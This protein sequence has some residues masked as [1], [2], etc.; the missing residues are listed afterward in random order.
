M[1]QVQPVGEVSP[2]SQPTSTVAHSN[3]HARRSAPEQ[4]DELMQVTSMRGWIALAGFALLLTAA[5]AWGLFGTVT[6]DVSGQ[7]VLVRGG[8]IKTQSS[9]S[10]GVVTSILLAS[11]TRVEKGEPLVVLTSAAGEPIQIASTFP[12]RVLSRHVRL[13][14]AVKTG[15]PLL[16][17]ESLDEPLQAYLYI[18]VSEG[19]QVEPSMRVQLLPASVNKDAFGYLKGTVVSADRF[20]VT[21]SELA[22]LLQNDNLAKT[23]TAGPPKLQVVVA[24]SENYK[25]PSGYAWSSSAGPPLELYSGTPCDGQIIV[26]EERP[27]HLVFRGWR[28]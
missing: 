13:G 10:D 27:I 17:L 25:T 22:E 12:C 24:L 20:P 6:T 8:G 26:A 23:L 18:P 2:A 14:E 11:G 28:H 3:P 21:Q 4:L 9:P 5:A 16:T 1:S 15:D 7:G 19:Y